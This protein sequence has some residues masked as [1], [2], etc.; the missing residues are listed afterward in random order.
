VSMKTFHFGEGAF[1][2]ALKKVVNRL[3]LND[4][5]LD[6]TVR[7]ILRDVQTKGDRGVIEYTEKFDRVKLKP[8]ELRVSE[9]EIRAAYNKA[10]SKVVESLRFAADRITAFHEGQKQVGWSTREKGVYLAQRVVPLER[11][12]LYVP[13][14]KASYPSSVLMN[15]IPARVAGV[16]RLVMT[17]PMPEGQCNPYILV[18]ADLV[19]VN[20]I[21]RVGGIQAIAALAYGTENIPKVD[22]IVGPGNKYVA[23]A[24]RFV[25]GLVGID[26]IAG[27][28]ELL[29]IAD[30]KANPAY[31]ASDLISQ[32]EHDE[33]ALVVFLSTSAA[34]VKNVMEEMKHQLITLPRKKIAMAA[35]KKQGFAF[36]VPD[37][38]T[39][40][41]VSNEIAPEHLSIFT[42]K[43]F[44]LEKKLVHAGSIFLGEDTPQSLGDYIAG[45]NHVLPTGG[46]ARFFSPLSVDDFIK[47]TSVISYTKRALVRDGDHLIRIAETE[48]LTAHANMVRIRLDNNAQSKV[49]S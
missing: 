1:N 44:K 16:K 3:N 40:V 28:S 25:F 15:A 4:D 7:T 30:D 47:K 39:A 34:L 24:K 42:E 8:S 6:A 32:A 21:C 31:L 11:V 5:S 18:A 48:G 27:P 23:A 46:T 41:R 49:R 17:T 10:D 35:L 14:G 26:M 13:G 43:P 36:V 19:G 22:K 2:T 20:E 9:K 37:L 38:E 12:G 29:I 33:E 45:P